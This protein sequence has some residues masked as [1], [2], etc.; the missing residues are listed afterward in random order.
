MPELNQWIE[1]QYGFRLPDG[2]VKP[3]E[4]SFEADVDY[5][6]RVVI[7]FASFPGATIV[8]RTITRTVDATDWRDE[9]MGEEP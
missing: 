2:T 9:T 6:R 7:R 4:R 1:I 8:S 3:V 5:R